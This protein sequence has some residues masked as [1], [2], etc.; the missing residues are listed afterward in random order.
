MHRIRVGV[1]AA[2]VLAT[3]AGGLSPVSAAAHGNRD[4]TL[5]FDALIEHVGAAGPGPEHAGHRQIA[6][7][8]L[9]D[10]GG[11]AAG[12]FSFTCTW[13]RVTS[14]GALERCVA[15]AWMPDGRLD[16][17]GPA[18]SN[19]TTHRWTVSG[20][21]GAYRSARGSV[22]VRD[23]SDR[24]SLITMSLTTGPGDVLRAG[25]LS[26]P[27]ANR[28]FIAHADRLCQ[29]AAAGLAALPPFPFHHFDPLH[30]DPS[31]LPK[32]GAFFTGPGDPRAILRALAAELHA[33]GLPPANHGGWAAALR[34][35][36][37]QLAV[38]ARQDQT[39]L[40]GDVHGFVRSVHASAV[41]FR[42]IAITATAFGATGCVF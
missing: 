22:L 4:R 21:A 42:D 1:L 33:L 8:A 39:A 17:T 40:A 41:N 12:R 19:S 24:E 11:R 31:L 5:L 16:A 3:C 34:A 38:I 35:R 14:D 27:R 25:V 18:R 20:G 28:R 10:A 36:S 26:L 9:R 6:S 32:V 23:L 7:G 29:R 2:T 13:T 37:A 30:P 15:T